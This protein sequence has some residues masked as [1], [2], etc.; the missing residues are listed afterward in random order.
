[1]R[2]PTINTAKRYARIGWTI[3]RLCA[4]AVVFELQN[5]ARICEIP[6]RRSGGTDRSTVGIGHEIE[7]QSIRRRDDI[8]IAVAGL[9]VP[10]RSAHRI[11]SNA[12]ERHSE[13]DEAD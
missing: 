10:H 11:S 4:G 7:P 5:R 3:R 12:G 6:R 1:M 8:A 2:I 13:A 9:E